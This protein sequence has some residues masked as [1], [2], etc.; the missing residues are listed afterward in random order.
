MSRDWFDPLGLRGSKLDPFTMFAD[1]LKGEGLAQ[2]SAEVMAT[3]IAR[4][5]VG[6]RVEIDSDPPISATVER[7]DEAIPATALAALPTS[8]GEVPM[9]QRVRGRIREVTVGE[10]TLKSVDLT[11]TGVRLVGATAHRI[12]VDHVEFNATVAPDEIERWAA[13]IDG[14][15]VVRLHEE[16]LEVTDRRV[17]RWAWLEVSVTAAR[18][19]IVVTPVALRILGRTMPMPGRLRRPVERDAS[20]LPAELVVSEVRLTDQ[21][22][23]V[24]GELDDVLVPVDVA[25][26]LT[27]IGA[28]GT[29][30]VL[31]VVVGDW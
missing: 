25:R 18:K 29:R 28:Q 7:I 15:H 11:V 27:E 10:R 22:A 23:G 14:D 2:Q 12:R 21:G 19:T 26:L 16:R 3:T 17:A 9:W 8:S 24:R 5:L 20:W 4:R 30:S 13:D 1:A 6:R 31:R